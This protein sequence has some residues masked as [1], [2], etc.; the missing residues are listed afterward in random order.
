MTFLGKLLTDQRGIVLFLSLIIVALLLGAGVGAIVSMQA[1]FRTTGN[2]KTATQAFYLAE[3]GIEWAKQKVESAITMPPNPA[4]GVVQLSPGNFAVSF[5]SP[6]NKSKMA[7][8]VTIRS[9]GKVGSSSQTVQALITRT[10]DLA[11]A[12]VGF[13]GNEAHASFVGDSFSVDGRDY[14]PVSKTL[15]PG[16]KAKMGVAVPNDTLR[17]QVKSALSVEQEDNVIGAETSVPGMGVTNFLSS[18]VISG[19]AYEICSA[20][21]A[22]VVDLVQAM[23]VPSPGE[24]TWGTRDSP[25]LRCVR[26]PAGTGNK[27]ALSAGL[28]GVGILIVRD[29]NLVIGG[30]FVWEG[31]IL[32]SGN[33]VGFNVEGGGIKEVFGSIL[34][35]ERGADSGEGTEEL[36]LQGAAS[37]RYSSA[38]LL[39]AAELIPTRI[40]ERLYA[41]LPSTITQD[42]WRAMGP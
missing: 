2:L 18:D 33:S 26:G 42:Y 7:A 14:D 17:E 4:A 31:L 21:E 5:L 34:I 15:V 16:A 23:S 10:Y 27:F 11:P 6:T 39:R 1:D 22:I 12:A 25:Q 13:T 37:V 9:T 30:P 35:D 40:L 28:S 20:P 38:A 3:A 29:A 24:T 32:V 19:L 36:K 8:S 41:S